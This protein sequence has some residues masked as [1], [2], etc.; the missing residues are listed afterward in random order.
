MAEKI[1]I[2]VYKTK[3]NDELTQILSDPD[4]R[5]ETGSG[6]A[7][8]ASVA[9]A[10]LCRAVKLAE[11]E[12]ESGERLAYL[13]RN[14]ETLRKYMVHLIDEDVKCRGPLRRAMQEGGA[15]EVEAARHPAVSIC[16]EIVNMMSQCLD[17]LLEVTALCPEAAHH[18]VLAGADCAMAAIKSA[19]RYILDMSGK[20]SE[21][22]YRFVT[23]RENEITLERCQTVYEQITK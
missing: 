4:S 1:L 17:M 23:R 13:A 19:I 8:T 18:Y 7:I 3:N 16:E 21:E 20:C 11:R 6:A 9:A 22:T 14:A 5:L 10:F 12:V 2:E 15:R